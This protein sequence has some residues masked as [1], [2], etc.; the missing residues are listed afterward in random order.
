MTDF[1]SLKIGDQ[2]I[3]AMEFR[4]AMI[5]W[6][7]KNFRPFPWR[8]T[9]DPYH[10]L[11]AEVM[12]HRTQAKQVV[13]VYK[14][15]MEVYPDIS[16]LAIATKEEI[17]EILHSLGLRWRID[18]I[19]A[20]ATDL[21]RRFSGCV[22]KNKEDL[23]SLPGVSLYIAS[24]VRCFA[25]NL[26]EPLVDTNTVR[27]TG[28]LYG[29]KTLESSR[30]NRKFINLISTLLDPNEPRLFNYSLLDLAEKVCFKKKP[31]DC[32]RCPIRM[33]CVYANMPDEKNYGY[34]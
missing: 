5:A 17:H 34:A 23:L 9:E 15:F 19:H 13:N 26:P 25:W 18:L 14:R 4:K 24:A 12:L 20:M 27:I 11:I 30:R 6:G 29:I 8:L 2:I 3:E 22:P 21:I 1:E 33:W 32:M 10:I 7:Q 31:P 28:R 16:L